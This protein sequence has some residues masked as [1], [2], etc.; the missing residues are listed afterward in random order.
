MASLF[1]DTRTGVF[2]VEFSDRTRRPRGKR[3]STSVRDSRAAERLRRLWESAYAEGTYDPWTDPPPTPGT[4]PRPKR[5]VTLAEARDQFLDSRAHRAANTIVNYER[6][7]GWFL[8]SVGGEISVS[9]IRSQ[10]VQSWI[11]SLD[12][13]PVTKANY[14]RHLRA[15]FR[16][17]IS[18][19]LCVV[20]VTGGVRL[21]R[22]P[23]QFPKALR[24][25][26]VESVA[27]YAE[28]HCRDGA[29]KSSAW[30]APFIR[31]GAET[32]MRRNELL[33][34][35]WEHIDLDAGHLTVACT[36][37]FTSKS[38][39]ERR[40]PLSDRAGDVLRRV[41]A[42]RPSR[43]GLVLEAGRGA[44]VH[45]GTCT[46]SVTRFASAAGVPALT[47]HVLRHSCITWLVERG[48]P[49]P[50]VQRLAGHADIATTMRYCAISDEVYAD[51]IRNALR[52]VGGHRPRSGGGCAEV[53]YH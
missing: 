35:R 18:E 14:V 13:K 3:V 30:A 27:V 5:V 31:L 47:P 17:C 7:T 25:E 34:L 22:V 20:D 8:A 46:K 10:H 2:V 1:K 51:Q 19:S 42:E 24:P 11:D 33:H 21:C 12:V 45:P 44:A 48:V 37:A 40:I 9:S 39:A 23:R 28:T 41:R 4:S 49:V 53:G 6:V 38:G 50:I 36:D 16:Y 29:Q 26:Q 52:C 32:A 15:F 43:S